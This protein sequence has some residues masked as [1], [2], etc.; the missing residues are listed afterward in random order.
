MAKE[1]KKKTIGMG[2]AIAV[3]GRVYRCRPRTQRDCSVECGMFN[4]DAGTC[5]GYC[6]RYDRNDIIFERVGYEDDL[7]KNAV[8][9]RTPY[10]EEYNEKLSA[11]RSK[12]KTMK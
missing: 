12:Q 9:F 2:D 4:A 6:Y 11:I 5:L 10:I 7:P 3:N 8:L 1:I